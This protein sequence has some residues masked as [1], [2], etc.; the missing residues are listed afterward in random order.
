M[1]SKPV[2]DALCKR[3]D[4]SGLLPRALGWDICTCRA[5]GLVLEQR[6]RRRA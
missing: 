6:E 4:D 1:A 5:G 3:C 2:D